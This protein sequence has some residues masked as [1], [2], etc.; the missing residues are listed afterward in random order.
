[1]PLV[2]LAGSALVAFTLVACASPANIENP[3]GSAAA[4]S[5]DRAGNRAGPI[6]SSEAVGAM[7]RP[8]QWPKSHYK[9]PPAPLKAS[10][11]AA[12]QPGLPNAA[13]DYD[14]ILSRSHANLQEDVTWFSSAADA[15]SYF[16]R[17]IAAM[18]GRQALCWP[19]AD[20]PKGRAAVTIVRMPR[21]DGARVLAWHF[22]GSP[23]YGADFS[24]GVVV[25]HLS[26]SGASSRDAN[27]DILRQVVGHA[28]ARARSA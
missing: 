21:V 1:M 23:T 3:L 27:P 8:N 22:N 16:N 28:A 12:C 4:A 6:T 5:G 2:R 9:A 25:G 7:L 19:A 17:L 24:T 15:A 10:V 13:A 18:R 20:P 26:L 14:E 11:R